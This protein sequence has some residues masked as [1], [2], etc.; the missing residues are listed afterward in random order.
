M[1]KLNLNKCYR[2]KESFYFFY[3]TVSGFYLFFLLSFFSVSNSIA[4]EIEKMCSDLVTKASLHI[5][6]VGLEQAFKDFDDRNGKFY[7]DK[8]Y[9]YTLTSN[10]ICIQHA[11][12]HALVGMDTRKMKDPSGKWFIKEMIIQ[13][14]KSKSGWITYLWT[15]PKTKKIEHKKVFYIRMDNLK[16]K[17]IESG[18]GIIVVSGF[19]I[20]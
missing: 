18:V 20:N 13:S 3:L 6:K 1:L 8:L 9:L 12:N 5:E 14:E 17:K 16:D 11:E 2:K 15:N 19:Y 7:S 4:N 10:G